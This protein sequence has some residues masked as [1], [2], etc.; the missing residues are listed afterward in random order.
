MT[1]PRLIISALPLLTACDA[2]WG[3]FA[4]T[5]PPT[6]T[7]EV[8]KCSQMLS[9]CPTA[10]PDAAQDEAKR[11]CSVSSPPVPT[12]T[13]DK[14]TGTSKK[15]ATSKL[16]LP[17]STG[18]M[19]YSADIDG[20][21]AAENQWKF[22]VDLVSIAGLD[23]QASLNSAVMDGDVT[24]LADL[25]TPDVTDA[26]CAGLTLAL[27]QPP[28]M[29]DPLPRYDGSDT[30]RIGATRGVTL[31]GGISS[32]RLSTTPSRALTAADAQ[33]L[34]FTLSLGGGEVLPL[35][36]HGVHLEGKLGTDRGQPAIV[37]GQLHGALSKKD[38]DGKI[39]PA[40]ASLVTKQINAKPMDSSTQTIINVFE[41]M[42]NDV[43]RNKCSVA[44]NRCC[45]TNPATC[46]ILPEEVQVS[47]IGG[48][49][50]SDVHA[51]NENDTWAPR[52]P[53]M[54]VVNNGLSFGLGFGAIR[55]AF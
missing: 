16:L 25:R 49:L 6:C 47:P 42:A 36:V 46:I 20:D 5:T 27:A 1:M 40:V 54:G 38:I 8:R 43:S 34:E 11:I 26:G 51:F 33:K 29:G 35:T 53:G 2:L 13:A 48:A 15:Y 45:K 41:N 3:G 24:I 31:Y 32:G 17:R 22:V 9:A 21:G 10:N 7:D 39:I 28:A 18:S 30:F 19:T 50:T 23:L 4:T 37:D 44:M 14:V 55:A 52:P 12:C